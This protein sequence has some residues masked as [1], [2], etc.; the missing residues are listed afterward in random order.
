MGIMHSFKAAWDRPNT[1]Y[2]PSSE[3][4]FS[5][6][7]YLPKLL[8]EFCQHIATGMDYLSRKGF[9]H[10]DLAARNILLT[11]NQTCKVHLSA[12]KDSLSH[13]QYLRTMMKCYKNSCFIVSTTPLVSSIV[14]PIN[15]CTVFVVEWVIS[16]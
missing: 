2:L 14:P 3:L 16:C 1:L 8:L 9:V 5:R 12:N 6:Q 7:S 10:R 4:I 13:S 15:V 11:E